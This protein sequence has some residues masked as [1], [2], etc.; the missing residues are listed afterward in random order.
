MLSGQLY[1]IVSRLRDLGFEFPS[2]INEIS[3][4]IPAM[5]NSYLN[6]SLLTAGANKTSNEKSSS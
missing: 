2:D 3:D 6:T 1:W 4:C 5:V